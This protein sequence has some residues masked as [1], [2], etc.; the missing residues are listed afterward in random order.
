MCLVKMTTEEVIF[1]PHFISFKIEDKEEA[2]RIIGIMKNKP[3]TVMKKIENKKLTLTILGK[4]LGDVV[5]KVFDLSKISINIIY[6]FSINVDFDGIILVYEYNKEGSEWLTFKVNHEMIEGAKLL[7]DYEL[8]ITQE[9]FSFFTDKNLD[10]CLDLS[11]EKEYCLKNALHCGLAVLLFEQ[12]KPNPNLL[13]NGVFFM[14]QKL[15]QEHL[16][17]FWEEACVKKK[18]L[19]LTTEINKNRKWFTF[20]IV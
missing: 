7:K 8:K 5:Y 14:K 20:G 18:T 4:R 1:D 3:Y 10:D 13:L 15:P 16:Y 6:Q 11:K 17:D 19:R 9:S 12:I 2:R